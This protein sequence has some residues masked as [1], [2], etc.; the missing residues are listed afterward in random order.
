MR[1]SGQD[2]LRV[3]LSGGSAQFLQPLLGLDTLIVEYLVLEGLAAIAEEE[4]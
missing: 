1:E 3:I 2:P 4:N